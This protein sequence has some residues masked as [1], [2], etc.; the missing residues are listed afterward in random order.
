M[1]VKV[2]VFLEKRMFRKLRNSLR[3]KQLDA[4]IRDEI[5]FHRSQTGGSFGNLLETFVQ[6][7]RIAFRLLRRT[8]SLTG[9]AVLSTALSVGATAVVFTAVQA[10]LLKPLPYSRPTELVQLGTRFTGAPRSHNDWVFWN[11]TQEIVRRTRTLES[12]GIYG[13]AVFDLGGGAYPPEALYGLRITASLFPT[14]G[15][16]PM[17]GRNILPEEDVYGRPN[18]LILSYGLWTRRFNGN[19]A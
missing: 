13:N 19:G 15:V 17:L 9:I 3:R 7:V 12:I 11:D 16:S 4:G 2:I 18:E 8:P 1:S 6:D 5:E 10:V 14:L